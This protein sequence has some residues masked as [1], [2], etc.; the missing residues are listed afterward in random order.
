MR[1]A[2]VAAASVTYFWRDE[3]EKI[4]IPIGHV[5]PL[6]HKIAAQLITF[7]FLSKLSFFSTYDDFH[8]ERMLLII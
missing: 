1:A 5:R 7:I 3:R 2:T 6:C 4:I 8:C